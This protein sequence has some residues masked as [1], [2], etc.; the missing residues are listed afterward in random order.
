MLRLYGAARSRAVRTLWMLGELADL[1]QLGSI[2]EFFRVRDWKRFV[3]SR[4]ESLKLA[5]V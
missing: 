1:S 2:E 3:I 5:V 4:G